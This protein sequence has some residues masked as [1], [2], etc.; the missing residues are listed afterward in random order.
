MAP[1]YVKDTL[2][3]MVTGRIYPAGV[4]KWDIAP[5]IKW[6]EKA[7][8][9]AQSLFAMQGG[10]MGIAKRPCISPKFYA[11]EQPAHEEWFYLNGAIVAGDT[12]WTVDDGSGNSVNTFI[13]VG[14][15]LQLVKPD[16]SAIEQVHVTTATVGGST[17]VVE[18]AYGT[19]S[20]TSWGDNTP[21]RVINN[22]SK[23]EV[24]I[25]DMTIKN[26]IPS[27]E[28]NYLTMIDTP[29]GGTYRF[30]EGK[31]QTGENPLELERLKAWVQHLKQKVKASL[32]NERYVETTYGTTISEGFIPA[33]LRRGGKHDIIGGIISFKR[34]MKTMDMAFKVGSDTKLALMPSIMLQALADWKLAKLVVMNEDKYLGLDVDTV[35]MSGYTLKVL[36]ER[37]LEGHP[38]MPDGLFGSCFLVVDPDNCSYRYFPGWDEKLIPDISANKPFNTLDV[39]HSD[40]GWQ[41]DIIESHTLASGITGWE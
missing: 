6:H 14:D 18:R 7:L 27:E 30:T 12:T 36:K 1:T 20:A 3:Q 19:S 5:Q 38:D 10:K 16:F 41:W 15:V 4:I 37:R 26:P 35:K 32:F 40:F 21:I 33:I 23:E 22:I 39:Y 25:A 29:M 34:F 17:I 31:L 13:K 2:T 28:Y 9:I 8:E 11:Y 24:K